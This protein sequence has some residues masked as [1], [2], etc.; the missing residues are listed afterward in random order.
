MNKP[1]EISLS[2]W[3]EIIQM[4][5]IRDAWGLEPEETLENFCSM[6]YGVRFDFVC[7]GPGYVG[8]VF[9]LLGDT[10][11]APFILIRRKGILEILKDGDEF[12]EIFWLVQSGKNVPP[13]KMVH[14]T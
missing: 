10:L 7:G 2:E 3:H 6:V 13:D 4:P 14:L 5:E 12:S 11:E 9:I 1:Y 8:D